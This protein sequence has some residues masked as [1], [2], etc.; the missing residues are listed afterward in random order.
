[1]KYALAVAAVAALAFSAVAQAE[2]SQAGLVHVPRAPG[3][4]DVAFGKQ[5]FGANCVSCHG[6]G[7]VGVRRPRAGAG[8]V[9]GQ[10]PSLRGVG[11]LSADFYLRTGYM[12]LAKPD[13]QPRRTRVLFSDGELDALVAYV[14]SLGDGPPVPRAPRGGDVSEGLSLFLS[15]CAG[16]HQILAQGGY[17]PSGVAP[18]LGSSTPRQIVEAIRLG[19]YLMPKFP[20]SQLSTAEVASIVRYVDYATHRPKDKGGWAIGHIGPVPEGLVAWL[21]AAAVLV[22]LAVVIG[23]RNRA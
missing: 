5:L 12:P 20:E 17:L 3:M 18:P 10:G 1:M 7:G 19:P 2:P 15:H 21:I 23:E 6:I 8:S 14:G 11:E 9:R 13:V 22:G 4:S 16:C